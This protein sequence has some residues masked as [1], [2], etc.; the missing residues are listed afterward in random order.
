MDKESIIRE[1]FFRLPKGYAEPPYTKIEMDILHEVLEENG[2]NGSIFVNESIDPGPKRWS[3]PY[4]EKYTEYEK[5]TNPK[6][7]EVDQLDQAFHDAE[8]VKDL[9]EQKKQTDTEILHE[10]FFAIAFA[11]IIEGKGGQLNSINSEESLIQLINSLSK[12]EDKNITIKDTQSVLVNYLEDGVFNNVITKMFTDAVM[13]ARSTKLKLDNIDAYEGAQY[14]GVKRVTETGESGLK[15]IADAT[16]QV[17]IESG[18][19]E[20]IISL[21]YGKG[22]FGSLSIINL[23]KYA[24]DIDMK[25]GLLKTLYQEGGD[26]ANAIDTTLSSYITLINDNADQFQDSPQYADYQQSRTEPIK[27]TQWQRG[28]WIRPYRKIFQLLNKAQKQSYIDSKKENLNKAIDKYITTNQAQQKDDF[29]DL[30]AYVFR[31]DNNKNYMY[32]AKGGKTIITIPSRS[33]IED[34]MKFLNVQIN[35]MKSEYGDYRRDVILTDKTEGT[36][37]IKLELLFRFGAGQWQGDLDH[38]GPAPDIRPEFEEFFGASGD[39]VK[40]V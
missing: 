34:R 19:E 33:L 32:V 25:Q 37:L 6:L 21:K 2:L 5:S 27:F 35:P 13:S 3:K 9:K 38:K 30:I 31:S 4:D 11:A 22:Q 7:K 8:P 12:L 39:E 23:L 20:L 10:N 18:D 1:W 24:F 29:S 26:Y 36:T 17:K 16:I 40:G 15:Q 28:P 14:I